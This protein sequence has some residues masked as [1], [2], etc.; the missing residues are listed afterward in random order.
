[1]TSQPRK[2]IHLPK[3]RMLSSGGPTK[4]GIRI[5]NVRTIKP[6]DPE[7]VKK[8]EEEKLR[9]QVYN[10]KLFHYSNLRFER[11]KLTYTLG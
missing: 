1:M 9:A 6:P 4:S 3:V 8:Q 7:H 10:N 5:T 2:L 11:R